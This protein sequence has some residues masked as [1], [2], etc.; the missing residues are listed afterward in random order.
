MPL[1]DYECARCGRFRD[2]RSK[3]NFDKP[4]ARG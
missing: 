1:Y 3:S 2:S 4:A